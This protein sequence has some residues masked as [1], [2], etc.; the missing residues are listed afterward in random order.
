MQ[1][2][3]RDISQGIRKLSACKL[4]QDRRTDIF[5]YREAIFNQKGCPHWIIGELYVKTSRNAKV[6]SLDKDD[7]F[8]N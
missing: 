1:K 3:I 5:A 7:R 4:F 6:N 2:K 8:L